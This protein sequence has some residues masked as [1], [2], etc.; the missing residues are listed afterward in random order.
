MGEQGEVREEM[1]NSKSHSKL[2]SFSTFCRTAVLNSMDS[3]KK[4]FY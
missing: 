2:N 1:K 3:N 4:H